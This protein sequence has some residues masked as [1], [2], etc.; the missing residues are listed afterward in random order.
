MYREL[1][2]FR[3]QGGFILFNPSGIESPQLR[4]YGN[5]TGDSL[6]VKTLCV[7]RLFNPD[8]SPDFE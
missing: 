6:I 7:I 2:F 1:K 5:P 3:E 8:H 4:Q